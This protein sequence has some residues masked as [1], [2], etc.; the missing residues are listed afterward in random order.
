[1][2][3]ILAQT[4][5]PF[6]I[7]IVDGQSTDNTATIAQSYP[8][9]RY[10]YQETLGLSQARNLGLQAAQGEFV[11]FLDSDDRWTPNKLALQVLALQN[12]PQ[13]QYVTAHLQLMADSDTSLRQGYL[14]EVLQKPKWGRTPGVLL[15]RRALFEQLGGFATDLRIAGDLEWFARAQQQQVPTQVL[16]EALLH[17]RIRGDSLSAQSQANRKE[18]MQVLRRSIAQRRQGTNHPF[19]HA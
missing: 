12:T 4:H 1:I 10:I 13:L 7:I 17:K 11:A 9:V 18:V 8:Q 5:A 15:A 6:E 2:N 14:P 19:G 16:P 3:S